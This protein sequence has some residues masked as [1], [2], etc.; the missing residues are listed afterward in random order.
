MCVTLKLWVTF[1]QQ[2]AWD[3][4]KDP[5][6]KVEKNYWSQR[7]ELWSAVCRVREV[8]EWKWPWKATFWLLGFLPFEQKGIPQPLFFVFCAHVAPVSN[9][10]ASF[11]CIDD[12]V[13]WNYHLQVMVCYGMLDPYSCGLT[14]IILL[15]LG[16]AQSRESYSLPTFNWH[17]SG[18]N[19][20]IQLSV[21]KVK[22]CIKINHFCCLVYLC[23]TKSTL[24]I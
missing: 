20:V 18:S 2:G 12:P 10:F 24:S 1:G 22:D 9:I 6:M 15:L 5:K 11:D 17:L 4:L 13:L 19:L 8:W 7:G 23:F 21:K 16:W 3:I 14:G